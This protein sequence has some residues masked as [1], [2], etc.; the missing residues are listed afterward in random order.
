MP[1]VVTMTN[2]VAEETETLP[3]APVVVLVVVL[4]VAAAVLEEGRLL[5]RS[6]WPTAR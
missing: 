4:V 3:S 2:K 6:G 5:L 1:V